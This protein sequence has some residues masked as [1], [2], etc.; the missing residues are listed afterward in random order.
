M[1]DDAIREIMKVRMKNINMKLLYEMWN[2]YAAAINAGDLD[3]WMNLWTDDGIQMAPYAPSRIGR[4]QIQEAMKPEFDRCDIHNMLIHI[5][6]V[7]GLGIWA[8]SY[9]TFMLDV[10]PQGG[11]QTTI[12][13]GKFLDILV[14]Q[15]DGSWKIAIDCHNYDQRTDNDHAAI[16]SEWS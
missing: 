13:R 15:A 10:S 1:I 7:R 11:G 3:R 5:E 8:Y 12:L 6:E 14:K 16:E 2:E 4:E 9:G